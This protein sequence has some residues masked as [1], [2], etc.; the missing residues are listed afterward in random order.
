ME[1]MRQAER[2]GLDMRFTWNSKKSMLLKAEQQNR[3]QEPNI[4]QQHA[5]EQ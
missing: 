1:Q 4:A 5:V 2:A 3:G